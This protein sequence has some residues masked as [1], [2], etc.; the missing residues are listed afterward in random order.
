M[1]VQERPINANRVKK[2]IRFIPLQFKIAL[3]LA[4]IALLVFIHWKVRAGGYK[5][6]VVEYEQMIADHKE[7]S[8]KEI[9]QIESNLN[10]AVKKLYSIP[11]ENNI[12]GS[13]TTYAIDSLYSPNTGE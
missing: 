8:R 5:A 9:L 12:A 1:R 13:R 11:S 3:G 10:D 6:C 2:M 7:V 4:L